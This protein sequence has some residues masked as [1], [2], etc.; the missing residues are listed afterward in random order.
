MDLLVCRLPCR[1]MLKDIARQQALWDINQNF[2]GKR[3]QLTRLVETVA[4]KESRGRSGLQR[5]RA[6][7]KRECEAKVHPLVTPPGHG[8]S[9]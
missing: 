8:P 2:D 1:Y 9:H 6:L 5:H 3:E 4:R 7:G